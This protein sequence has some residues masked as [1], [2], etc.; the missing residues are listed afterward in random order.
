MGRGDVIG[1]VVTWPPD[2]VHCG[3]S[4]PGAVSGYA[5]KGTPVGEVHYPDEWNTQ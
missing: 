2:A 1:A 3:V 5:G 4:A